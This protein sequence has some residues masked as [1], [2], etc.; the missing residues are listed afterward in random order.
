MVTQRMEALA[1]S[2]AAKVFNIDVLCTIRQRTRGTRVLHTRFITNENLIG[3][4]NGI[5]VLIHHD[6]RAGWFCPVAFIFGER[7]GLMVNR[8]FAP[9]AESAEQRSSGVNLAL[10]RIS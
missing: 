9:R 3:L 4:V 6:G 10:N 8:W 2:A 1:R 7:T 5:G